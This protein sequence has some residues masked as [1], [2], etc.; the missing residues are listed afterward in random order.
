MRRRRQNTHDGA[1]TLVEML[2]VIL[3]IGILV[4]I[5]VGVSGRAIARAK[6]AKTKLF[7]GTITNAIGAYFEVN[8]EWP[9]ADENAT[10][11]DRS[12]QLFKDLLGCEASKLRLGVIGD[13]ARKGRF[14]DGYKQ[15]IDYH[16]SGGAGGAAYLESAGPDGDYSTIDDNIR[17]DNM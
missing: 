14:Y 10:A 8:R 16:H 7:M 17:S 15:V 4:T 5:V 3:V 11:D 12:A 1:F 2:A 9:Q 13:V 6:E